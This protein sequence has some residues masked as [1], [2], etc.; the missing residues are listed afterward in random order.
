MKLS[1]IEKSELDRYLSCYDFSASLKDKTFLI[2]G[3]KGLCGTGVIKWLLAE[4]CLRGTNVK[5]IA[6][7]R[8]PKDVPAYIELCDNIVFCEFGRE[9]EACRGT[10]VDYI[11]HMACPTQRSFL[12]SNPVETLCIMTETTKTVLDIASQNSGVSMVYLSSEEVYGITDLSAPVSEQYVGAVNSLDVRSCYPLGKKAAEL[13]CHSHSAEYGTDVK[14]VRFPTIQGLLQKYGEEHITSEVLRCVMEKKDL[15]LRS[16]GSTKKCIIYLL[17]AVSAIFSVLF[18]GAKGEAYNASNPETF[19]TVKDMAAQLFAKFSPQVR[20]VF[21]EKDSATSEGYLPRRSLVQDIS[22]IQKLG[23]EPKTGLERIYEIDIRRFTTPKCQEENKMATGKATQLLRDFVREKFQRELEDI[24]LVVYGNEMRTCGGLLEHIDPNIPATL[25]DFNLRRAGRIY[26]GHECQLP[27]MCVPFSD[28]AVVLVSLLYEYQYEQIA[29]KLTL[30][31]IPRKRIAWCRS[32]AQEMMIEYSDYF[33]NRRMDQK[34]LELF[35]HINKDISTIRYLDIGANHFCLYNNTYLFY[36]SGARGVLV[37]ANPDLA[38]DIRENRPG[39]VLLSC[40]CTPGDSKGVLTYY[41]TN[42]AGY[43]TF[44]ESRAKRYGVDIGCALGVHVIDTISVETYPI[45][46]ILAEQFPEKH[47]DFLSVDIE[48]LSC[49]VVSNIDFSQ[50]QVDVILVEMSPDAM[51]TRELYKKLVG[52]NYKMVY[53]G[54]G[55]GGDFLFYNKAV[56]GG[57]EIIK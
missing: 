31:G 30:L 45:N 6:S 14:I 16:D 53:K 3:S 50:Y 24:H 11:I 42:R 27:E 22:K 5:I 1:P 2:T 29:E 51:E 34:V 32:L 35:Q 28:N 12:R 40:G 13:L 36:K 7:T 26:D 47:I 56:F 38:E 15:V 21:P 57:E 55:V 41:R 9:A 20:V 43:N 10:Q 48:G 54:I 23:W 49:D 37:E 19:M 17:D 44:V 18:Y 52:L 4:N 25:I 39:D 33:S 46:L 8:D